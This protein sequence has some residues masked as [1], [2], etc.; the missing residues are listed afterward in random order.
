MK[1]KLAGGEVA[2]VTF[3]GLN[4]LQVG[5]EGDEL[6]KRNELANRAKDVE[7]V[8]N[9][10]T[11]T[12]AVN[13]VRE[14]R[15]IEKL[16]EE[17]RS[18][19]KGPVIDLGRRIDD[20]AKKYLEPILVEKSRINGMMDRYVTEQKKKAE[21]I[22]RKALDE[23]KRLEVERQQAMLK[24]QT[25]STPEAAVAANEAVKQIEQKQAAALTV[26][27]PVIPKVAG[28][29]TREVWVWDPE[30]DFAEVAKHRPDLCRIE[31]KMAEVTAALNAG[32]KIPGIKNPRK[33]S[34]VIA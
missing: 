21:E 16:V 9:E 5:I 13:V 26:P 4:T 32:Q 6:L 15:E 31:L 17:T 2:P 11:H 22:E 14:I 12:L 19:I 7:C 10:F 28:T 27:V 3:E 30:V 1:L 23:A 33:E 20:C 25:A 29:K 24:E 18:K 8:N 34:K